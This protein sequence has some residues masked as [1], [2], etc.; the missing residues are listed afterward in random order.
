MNNG[1][2]AFSSVGSEKKKP[3]F[4]SNKPIMLYNVIFIRQC[5]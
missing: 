5:N 4:S 2:S 1:G 3:L